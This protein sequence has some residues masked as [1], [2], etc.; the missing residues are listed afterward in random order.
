MDAVTEPDRPCRVPAV[1]LL[2][3]DSLGE[4]TG[5]FMPGLIIA[6]DDIAMAPAKPVGFRLGDFVPGGECVLGDKTGEVASFTEER[7]HGLRF[8]VVLFTEWIEAASEVSGR[9]SK[10]ELGKLFGMVALTP[11]GGL[12]GIKSDILCELMCV[13]DSTIGDMDWS[14]GG[15]I[16]TGGPRASGGAVALRS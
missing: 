14:P 9:P 6:M 10:D 16:F 11:R 8:L 12:A 3:P 15:S 7:R 2:V 4:I 5:T 13:G 1:V